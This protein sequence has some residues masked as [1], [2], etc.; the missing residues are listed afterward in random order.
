MQL[1]LPIFALSIASIISLVGPQ[2]TFGENEGRQRISFSKKALLAG[3]SIIG[4]GKQPIAGRGEFDTHF[5]FIYAGAITNLT[6]GSEASVWLPVASDSDDQVI[7][8]RRI[9]LPAE[10][11][12]DRDDVFGNQMVHF[13]GTANEAGEIPFEISY[14][15]HRKALPAKSEN[16]VSQASKELFLNGSSVVPIDRNLS[17]QVLGEKN[18]SSDTMIAGRMIYDAVNQRMRYDKPEGQSWGRGDSVWACDNGFGNCTDFHSLFISICREQQIPAK[19]EI[20]FPIELNDKSGSIGGYHCW[21][22]FAVADRWIPVDISEASKTPEQS[23]FFFGNLPA[24]R[25]TFSMGRDLILSP[26]QQGEPV[27]F[28]VYPYV[29]V[30]G[31]MHTDFRKDFRFKRLD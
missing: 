11:N 30:D 3:K 7:Q 1:P 25:I 10:F 8:R 28:L 9:Q 27:N 4:K 23:E 31:E 16:P 15:F 6:P 12:I 24:D 29:E 13:K 14:R 26:A 17:K 5:Q 21:A 19:F 22:K 2:V 18:L 20:G